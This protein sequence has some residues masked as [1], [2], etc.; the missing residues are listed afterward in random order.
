MFRFRRS[1]GPLDLAVEMAGVRMGERVIQAGV[2]NPRVFAK[3]ASLVGLTGRA[4]A[5]VDT[6][7]GAARL[8]EAAADQGV[9]VEVSFTPVVPWNHADGSFDVALLDGNALV[10][11]LPA[12]RDARLIETLRVVR[13]GGRLLAI[14]ERPRGLAGRLGFEPEHRDPTPEARVL[15]QALE[16]AG[17]RP[18]RVL[19]EREG[20]AFVEG[21]CAATE[22]ARRGG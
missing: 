5:V 9:L 10:A 20:L 19:A 4:C 18:V 6:P 15:L 22:R 16:L 1:R 21:F 13:P 3:V 12:E 8:E 14:F 11:G 2:G 7:A 17:C